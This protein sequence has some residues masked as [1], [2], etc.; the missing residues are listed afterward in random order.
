MSAGA[1]W[2]AG[3]IEVRRKRVKQPSRPDV[4]EIPDL[5]ENPD[6]HAAYLGPLFGPS[7][8]PPQPLLE[9]MNK[10]LL[11]PLFALCALALLAAAWAVLGSGGAGPAHIEEVGPGSE[12]LVQ[13]AGNERPDE[14]THVAEAAA[15]VEREAVIEEAPAPQEKIARSAESLPSNALWAEGVVIFPAKMPLDAGDVEVTARGRRFGGKDDPRREYVTGIS[16]DGRFR[17][18]FARSTR[19]GWIELQ[20]RYLYTDE[21]VVVEMGDIDQEIVVEPKLGGILRGELKAPFGM[22][23][24]DAALE[25]SKVS[26][27]SWGGG[28]FSRTADIGPD[29]RFE[30]PALPP[31]SGYMFR[32]NPSLWAEYSEQQVDVKAGEVTELSA[33]LKAGARIN[34]IVLDT[35]GVAIPNVAVELM[36]Q[37]LEDGWHHQT[38]QSDLLGAFEFHGVVPGEVSITAKVDNALP[39]QLELG[40]LRDGD[41]RADL[42]VEL[43]RGRS[44]SGIVRWPDGSPVVGASVVIEQKK[45]TRTLGMMFGAKDNE[46]TDAEGAFHIAGLEDNICV[47]KASA[48]S[49]RPQDKERAEETGKRIRARGA[50]Y[51]VK[52][53]DVQPGTTGLVLVLEP[54]D[55]IKGRAVD[56][57]GEPISRLLVSAE[58]VEG[59]G[60]D[61]DSEDGFNRLVVTLDG[62][63]VLEGLRDGDWT[64]TARADDHASSGAVK[65]TSPDATEVEFVL[66]RQGRIEGLVRSPSGEPV[67]GASVFLEDA[68][69][70]AEHEVSIRQGD[71]GVAATTDEEGRFVA[72]DVN[73]G[74]KAVFARMDGF[75]QGEPAFVTLAAGETL[76]NVALRLRA[77]AT[78]EGMV[79][80]AAGEIGERQ[81]QIQGQDGLSYWGSAKSDKGGEFEVTGLSPGRY[82]L[83]LQGEGAGKTMRGRGAFSF[84]ASKDGAELAQ[85]AIQYVDVPE[86][87][88]V[89]VVL[90]SPPSNPI[91]VSGRVTSGGKP[92]ADYAVSCRSEEDSERNRASAVTDA[93]G[94]YSLTV[95][96]AGMYRF[97]VGPPGNALRATHQVGEGATSIDFELPAATVTG[98]VEGP[99]GEAVAGASLRLVRYQDPDGRRVSGPE[100]STSSDES[101]AYTFEHLEPGTYYLLVSK[102][103]GWNW[104]TRSRGEGL[105]RVLIEGIAVGASERKDGVNVSLQKGG[106]VKGT[107]LGSD[108]LGVSS[109]YVVVLT[110]S[111]LTVTQESIGSDGSFTID[112]LGEGTYLLRT[113]GQSHGHDGESQEVR[114]Y[115]ESETEADLLLNTH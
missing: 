81:I 115:S 17:V 47:V 15:P 93:E 97:S 87:G 59:T 69:E 111:G 58:P 101:G 8:D 57:R 45:D 95:S 27:T 2:G 66:P 41:V 1:G 76:E 105:G 112:D 108:G 56:D 49:M 36:C 44:I 25:G 21:K 92:V 18:A 35:E 63:F 26:V 77:G 16:R 75:A 103:S 73:P 3:I 110:R 62:S 82:R 7:R 9:T 55:R 14:L 67:S 113:Q 30:L 24:S 68:P 23:W 39:G 88:R 54:G 70:G 33:Q 12:G 86:G 78:I 5:D 40:T 64:L 91:V 43:D 104:R 84:T 32:A 106:T 42:K 85:N 51:R 114:V 94:G 90:G 100:R 28:R 6:G 31:G 99:T 46:R 11:L 10:K 98:V 52:V 96:G 89:R 48:R 83:Q 38:V 4:G 65:I 107:V 109:G 74:L 13:S 61:L 34:G 80:A 19:K 72:K 22:S 20:G 79:H 71:W 53:S 102:R 50:T 37:P 60:E 29:G